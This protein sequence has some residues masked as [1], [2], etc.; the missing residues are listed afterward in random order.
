MMITIMNKGVMVKMNN[1]FINNIFEEYEEDSNRCRQSNITK[2][3][4]D[5]FLIWFDWIYVNLLMVD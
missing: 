5:E 3:M 4:I 1:I 2:I